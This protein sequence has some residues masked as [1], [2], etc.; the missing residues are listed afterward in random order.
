[1]KILVKDEVRDLT[2]VKL[3]VNGAHMGPISQRKVD[4]ANALRLSAAANKIKVMADF[5]IKVNKTNLSEDKQ[6]IDH[7]KSYVLFDSTEISVE[8]VIDAALYYM[9]AWDMTY[10]EDGT[11][12]YLEKLRAMLNARSS[13]YSQLGLNPAATVR[14][15]LTVQQRSVY[16]SIVGP[17]GFDYYEYHLAF[18]LQGEKK[19]IRSKTYRSLSPGNSES[20]AATLNKRYQIISKYFDIETKTSN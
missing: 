17:Y 2:Y 10:K 20:I 19:F 11:P 16:N 1:M 4:R 8:Q 18:K 7:N 13:A 6:V 3:C 15:D 9:Q 12:K 14:P 5:S